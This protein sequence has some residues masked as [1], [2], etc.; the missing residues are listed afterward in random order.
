MALLATKNTKLK[1]I[2]NLVASFFSVLL[3]IGVVMY[4]STSSVERVSSKTNQL[5]KTQIPELREISEAQKLIAFISN[6]LHEYYATLDRDYYLG[7]ERYIESFKE[8]VNHMTYAINILNVN[9][10]LDHHLA[11]FITHAN[12]FDAEMRRGDRRNWDKLRSQL[13]AAQEEAKAI[14][15]LLDDRSM[16]ISHTVEANSLSTQNEVEHLNLLQLGF[17]LVVLVAALFI[18]V[19]LHYRIKDQAELY[20]R[21]YY[22]S[23]T[24]LPNRKSF[25]QQL[26]KAHSTNNQPAFLLVNLDR[27]SLIT[28]TMGYIFGDQLIKAISEWLV[29]SLERVDE[30]IAIYHFSGTSWLIALPNNVDEKQTTDIANMLTN[31]S[32]VTFNLNDREMTCSCSIGVYFNS[33]KEIDNVE[34]LSNLDTA[35]REA[36][37]AGGNCYHVFHSNMSMETKK[38]I[39]TEHALRHAIEKR[40]FELFYQPKINAQT[41]K[42]SSSEALLRWRKNGELISPAIFIPIAESSNLIINIGKWV[43]LEACEQWVNW[44]KEGLPAMP[45]AINISARQFQEIDFPHEVQSAIL[46]T[47]IPAE[48]LELEITEEAAANEPKHVVEIMCQLKK[49]GVSL[50]IDDFGTGYSSLSH[51]RHF[52]IDVLKIDRAFI[53]NMN[54]SVTDMSIVKLILQLAKQLNFKV[55]AEGVETE[56]QY[57]ELKSLECE[58]IQGFW[59]SKPLPAAEFAAMLK[60]E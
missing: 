34:I 38:W 40:E 43:L 57:Q 35:L 51:L 42:V 26:N 15:L 13:Y 4:I 32:S 55:V 23:I 59:F 11:S 39:D 14:S 53:K 17:S 49:I 22:N 20:K 48:M 19:N 1:N 56:L 16:G 31:M 6:N 54:N 9:R 28:G 52:P 36:Q 18:I 60:K 21:A 30:A 5:I 12:E 25:E 24:N 37:K 2:I 45:I 46:K 47:G 29:N 27:F 7:N 44:Q 10:L 33:S 3:L 41:G 8:K 50:A 58:L